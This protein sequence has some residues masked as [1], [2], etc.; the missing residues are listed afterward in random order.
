MA[1]KFEPFASS[2]LSFFGSLSRL[3][4]FFLLFCG[5]EQ[6]ETFCFGLRYQRTLI[7]QAFTLTAWGW[8]LVEFTDLVSL[9]SHARWELPWA[10]QVS[11]V[12]SLVIRVTFLEPC[13]IPLLVDFYSYDLLF[14]FGENLPT[15]TLLLLLLCFLCVCVFG[16]SFWMYF[17]LLIRCNSLI[18]SIP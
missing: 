1:Q 13:Y 8:T 2:K 18:S 17:R 9:H 3:Y 11:V 12:V 14:I 16:P 5:L 10:I 6:W 15:S 4:V 7:F